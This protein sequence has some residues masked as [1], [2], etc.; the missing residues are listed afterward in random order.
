M[1]QVLQDLESVE[2]AT[3]HAAFKLNQPITEA[4]PLMTMY[5]LV[6]VDEVSLLDC[7]QFERLIKLWSV[8][9]KVP[10]LVFL[11]DKY[12]LPGVGETRPWE[13]AAWPRPNCYHVKLDETWRCK[14]E[15]FQHI[16]DEL[17]TS[18]PSK[19]TLQKI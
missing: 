6:V 1:K 16:L 2:I 18:K 17:R 12:Q 14:E 4:L 5:D 19:E 7:P 9:E 13:S 3:C 10:A 11:G 8:A 15:R